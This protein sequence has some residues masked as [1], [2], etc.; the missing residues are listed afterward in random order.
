MNPAFNLPACT[1]AVPYNP[2]SLLPAHRL[3]VTSFLLPQSPAVWLLPASSIALQHTAPALA[4]CSKKPKKSIIKLQYASYSLVPFTS[5]KK[6]DAI[7]LGT[8]QSIQQISAT[9][10]S[11]DSTLFVSIGVSCNKLSQADTKAHLQ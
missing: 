1:P 8:C 9:A 2:T 3:C 11:D 6:K 7:I 5:L 4:T 10:A